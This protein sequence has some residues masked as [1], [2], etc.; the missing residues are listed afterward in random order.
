MKRWLL[1]WSLTALVCTGQTVEGYV[2]GADDIRLFYRKVGRG[3]PIT[4]LLH[5]GPGSSISAAWPDL[6]PLSNGRAILMYDQRGGG[7]SELIRDSKLL[8]RSTP[9]P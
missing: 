6:E 2:K 9:R 5:G 4:I 3:R 7:R 1:L 8:Q